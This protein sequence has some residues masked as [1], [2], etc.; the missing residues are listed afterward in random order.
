M[1]GAPSES[2]QV[3]LVTGCSSGIGKEICEEL[4]TAGMRVYGASRSTCT[5]RLWTYQS[6]DVTDEAAVLAVVDEIVRREGRIDA[7]VTCAG[8]SLAGSVEDTSLAEAQRQLD[9]N[10]YGTVRVIRAVLPI[11]RKQRSGKLVVIGSIGGLI[12]LPYIAYY[13]AAK[14]ALDG[15]VEALRTEVEPFGIQATI[16]HPGDFD[17]Q[18]GVNRTY[19]AQAQTQSA[20]RD[21]FE[22]RC[23]FYAAQENKAPPPKAVAHKVKKILLLRSLPVR[24]IVGSPLEKL[25]VLAKALLPSRIFE[26]VLRI[27]YAP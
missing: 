8:I 10:F 5:P 21:A 18:L 16:V 9:T 27:A 4:G 20:Y 22:K 26:L 19:S 15:L 24:V 13:S 14:F 17:T 3:V 25:G 7:V 6:M 12:G 11:M 23:A 1:P 2:A